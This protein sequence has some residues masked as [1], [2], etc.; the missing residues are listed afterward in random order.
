MAFFS[1]VLKI[2]TSTYVNKGTNTSTF[3]G[4]VDRRPIN[5][6]ENIEKGIID[7]QTAKVEMDLLLVKV[8][9]QGY[10]NLSIT[11]KKRLEELSKYY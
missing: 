10:K 5:I 7:K 1:R 3:R 8:K 9:K 11:D 2:K 4:S 6:R